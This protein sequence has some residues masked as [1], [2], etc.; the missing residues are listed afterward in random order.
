MARAIKLRVATWVLGG[1]LGIIVLLVALLHT[2]PLRRY[3]LRQAIEILGAQGIRFSAADL[4]YN[5][6]ELTATLKNVEVRSTQNPDLPPVLQ[7]D[8]VYVDLSLRKLLQ[9]EY[10]I[11]D[12]TVRDPNLHVLI[13]KDG[14]DNIPRP[15]K[16]PD[17]PQSETQFFIDQ[18][19]IESGNLRYEDQRQSLTASLP[20]TKLTVDGNPLTG[21]HQIDLQAGSTGQVSF[22][23]RTLPIRNMTASVLLEENAAEIKSL[24]VGLQESTV[25]LAGRINNFDDPRFDVRA[26]TTLAL[27]P[28]TQFA[29]VNQTVRGDVNVSLAATGPI[30]QLEAKARID[31]QDLTIDK[32]NDVDLKAEAVYD[33]GSSRA[34]IDSLNITSPAGVIR[35]TANLALNA[36]AGQS[37]ANIVT[38]NLDLGR[39]SSTF[40]A[41]VRV[42]SRADAKIEARWPALEFQQAAGNATISLAAT[43]Q[44][45]ARDVL[46]VSGQLNLRT[47]GN[48]IVADIQRLRTLNATASG[49]VEITN[50]RSLDGTVKIVTD[51]LASTISA[52]EAFLGRNITDTP[53]EGEAVVTAQLGGTLQNPQFATNIQAPELQLG[54]L[55]AVNIQANANYTGDAIA[56]KNVDLQWQGQTITASGTVGLKGANP[57]I[58]LTTRTQ[59]L[60]IQSVLA[61]LNQPDIPASGDVQVDA[62]ITGTTK[63]PVVDATVSATDLTAYN[64]PLGTLNAQAQVRGDDVTITNLTLNKPQEGE[65]GTLRASGTYNLETKQFSLD[66]QSDNLRLTSLQLPDGTPLRGEIALNANVRGQAED[67]TGTIKLAANELVVGDKK[68]GDLTVAANIVNGIADVD[69][70]APAFNV[71]ADAQIGIKEPYPATVEI[72]AN[73]TDLASL[74]VEINQPIKGTVSAVVRAK[75]NLTEYQKGEATAEVS[76]LNLDING[77][78]LRTEGPLVA[79]YDN[80]RLTIDRATIVARDSRISL[81]GTLPLEPGAGQGEIK[82]SSKLDLG[83]LVQYLPDQELTAR[84]TATIDG[85][86]QG[87]LQRID[88]NLNIAINDAFVSSLAISPPISNLNVQ[89]QVQNGALELQTLRADVGPATIT[90][91][92]TVPFGMLPADLP[93]ELPRRQGPAQLTAELSDLDLGTIRALPDEMSGV[94]SARLEASATKPDIEAVTGRLTFP[95]LRLQYESITLQQQG[96]SEIALA[97]GVAR[98]T[99]FALTGPGT[100]LRLAGTAGLTGANPLDLQLKGTT[101]L[102]LLGAIAEDIRSEGD[103]QLQVAVNGTAKNPQATGFV[104]VN[105]GTISMT[106]PR[107]GLENLDVRVNL[108]GTRATVSELSAQLNG[109]Q[110]TGSG[111]VEFANGQLRNTNLGVKATGVYMDVPEGLKTISDF[112]LTLRDGADDTVVL[113]GDVRIED[114]G[115]TD[116]LNFDRGLLAAL[117]G[118][119]GIDLTEQPNPL[120][121]NIRLNVGVRTLNPI[122]IDNNLAEA[123]VTANLRVLGTP[124][125]LGLSGRL[126][127]LEGGEIRLQEREYLVERG[128]ITFVGDR[129]IEPVMDI[130]ATT[131]A[132]GYDVRLQ[133]TGEPGETETTLTSDPP[134]PEPDILA[135]LLTGRTLEEIRGQEFEVARNQVLSYLTGRVGSTLGRGIAGATGLSMVRIEPSL[136]AAEADPSARLTVG[137]DITRNIQLIYSMDLINSADQIYVAEYDLNRRF[138]TRGTR[139]SDGS[140]RFD[141]RHD[142][143]FGG[144]PEP[145]RNDQRNRRRIGDI[146]I[147]GEKYFDEMKIIDKFDIETGDRYDFFKVRKGL[148]RVEKMYR[149][150]GLLESRVRLRRQEQPATLDLS[151]NI[152]P[153][154]VVDFVFEGFSIPDDVRK[155]VREIWS[156]GVFDTQRA[157]E[158]VEAIRTWLVK[159]DRLRP[160]IDYAIS[161]PGDNRKRVVFDIQPGPEFKNVEVVFDGAKAFSNEDLREVI[162]RQDLEE[163]VYIAP[164]RVTELLSAFY[165]EM[166]YLDAEVAD[167]RYELDS[168]TATGKVV[169]P[170]NEGPLFKVGEVRFEG[171]TVLSDEQ[172]AAAVPLP[173]GE[174]YRPV[175][176]ANSLDRLQQEYWDIGFNDMEAEYLISRSREREAVDITFQIREGRQSVVREIIIEGNDR[177]S[178]NLIRTQ[179]TLDAGDILDLGKLAESRKNLYNTGAYS[180]VE[181][182]RE[183]I[184]AEAEE[185]PAP[186]REGE[187]QAL[188]DKPIR[189]TIRV[190]E[191]QPYQVRY[192]GFFDT[193]RGPG[194][195]ADI[196]TRNTLG[197]ARILGLRTRYDSQLQEARLY[198]S[199]PMLRRFPLRTIVSPYLRRERNPATSEVDPFNVDRVGFSLQQEATWRRIYILNYGYRIERSRTFDPSPEA[200]FDVPLRVGALT[201]TFSRETRDE[202]LDATRGSFMSHAVQWSPSW[203]GS[204]IRFMKYFG[205]YFRYIPLQKPRIELFTNQVERPR[206]VYAGGVRLGLAKGFGQEVPLAERFFAGG[207]TTMRGFEQ[208]TVG[209][210]EGRQATGGEAMLVVNNEIRFPIVSIFDGVGFVDIGNVYRRVSDF[211]LTDIRKT[212]GV[213]LRVR[214]PWFLLRLDYGLKLDRQ[215]GETRGRLF[216]SIGQAF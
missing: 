123:E 90:A 168:A 212:A 206:L 173:K 86:I 211:S 209:E 118:E 36:A 21:N 145:R 132:G 7:A 170:V 47:Q 178:E 92:G 89:A 190:R 164:D 210:I 140:Y 54:Q 165:R 78:P 12:A 202:I 214:T 23:T 208:N 121:E 149:K 169:F 191:I 74:P 161:T 4:N 14:R 88:P 125:R 42:A 162:D 129:R 138:T 30:S 122:I 171:N 45:A 29:G 163:E 119:E 49:N 40:E 22:E 157:E 66:A 177:T 65:D 80:Q 101:D 213:G 175:L 160:K 115:F 8:S 215:P 128:V 201:S 6:L 38:R 44:S 24:K 56:L 67:P 141:F 156:A 71:T 126:E 31:G 158:S 18:L 185:G 46:P 120:L 59:N 104:E 153:G 194:G 39:L 176:R 83:T 159:E 84:G 100:D 61:G 72:R 10:H 216:F 69:V 155:R 198:F 25:E 57:P 107:I 55:K 50:R 184:G 166:G 97:N 139:Q 15:P 96:T 52:A 2:P 134:L 33:A 111:T 70:A 63:Q 95:Q 148:D 113:A 5:L 135:L 109:G 143:R 188:G 142:L 174:G 167:P 200:I 32:L 150:A 37:T 110:L 27:G 98:V 64:E 93:V 172:L 73:N 127:I 16:K 205:Q 207:S 192:G 105:D 117:G 17:E 60:K 203:V 53:V 186:A 147:I 28:L 136:I 48:R 152:K 51:G 114:G 181:I 3:A 68:L 58:D 108:A 151:L 199:Q 131:N 35:G 94:V 62:R 204:E 75:G 196:Y 102:A 77:Q 183:V 180:L 99:N 87:T 19:L 146:D 26:D 81:S 91:S 182:N 154:P 11:E 13:T 79:H 130:L 137:Q 1:L 41:P 133:I 195:I 9:G 187:A 76:E 189:M 124:N 82:L 144:T 43:R 179:V 85:T 112:E 20:L 193:E 103:V 34:R 106:D 116:D 197:S